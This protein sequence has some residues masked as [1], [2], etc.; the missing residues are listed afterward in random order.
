MML[1]N[2][3]LAWMPY[4]LA[5]ALEAL[6]ESLARVR[7]QTGLKMGDD[8]GFP[9]IVGGQPGVWRP[10]LVVCFGV[11]WLM[12]LPNASYLVTDGAHWQPGKG[13][14][15]WWDLI[16]LC[17]LAW[18]GL[19]LT[20][21]SVAG[22]HEWVARRGGARAGWAFALAALALA[23]AGVYVGRFWRWNSWE[24]ATRPAVLAADVARLADGGVAHRAAVFAA[25][26]FT[27]CVMSYGLL[28]LLAGDGGAART[29][30]D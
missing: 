8:D 3:A 13:M 5:L 4:L 7:D 15:V 12:F 19:C 17:A 21:G 16:Y 20:Y 25:G 6:L 22:L 10:W 1:P 23:T 9:S 14:P 30:M 28:H 26:F 18:T 29:R 2:L 27:L 11:L 24:V